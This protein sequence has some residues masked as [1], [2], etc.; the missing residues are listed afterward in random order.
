MRYDPSV[1]DL[2]SWL[3]PEARAA[4][5]RARA[6][7]L[8]YRIRIL[9]SPDEPRRLL[10]VVGEAHV[11]L[12]HASALGKELVDAFELRGVETFPTERVVAGRA[13]KLLVDAPR[14]LIRWLSFGLVKDSTIGDARAATR[15]RTFLL[16]SVSRI[17][18]SLHFASVYFALFFPVM[19]SLL[20]I[21]PLQAW[22][23]YSFVDRV[24]LFG[25]VFACH[26]PLILLAFWL[27]RFRGS[28]IIHPGIAILTA[29]NAMMAEGT[30]SMLRQHPLP[31]AALVIMGRGH[32]R[33]YERELMEKYGYTRLDWPERYRPSAASTDFRSRNSRAQSASTTSA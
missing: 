26:L 21:L 13:L 24:V 5:E 8:S 4:V 27:R 9:G 32:L 12:A 22:V 2:A 19:Y 3:S 11:K 20:L 29:R 31:P 16:E 1:V 30:M 17:P 28:W 23:P 10:V 7:P 33:G 25:F 14:R 18:L 6:Q 15:G